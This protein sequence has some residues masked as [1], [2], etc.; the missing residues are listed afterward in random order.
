MSKL[1][2]VVLALFFQACAIA[3]QGYLTQAKLPGHDF[4]ATDS[5]LRLIVDAE[6]SIFST[7]GL[8]D[9]KRILC[10]EPSPDVATTLAHSLGASISVLNY[11]AGSLSAQQV[12]GLVQLGERTAAVQ[13]LR[14]KMYQICVAYANDAISATTYSLLMSRLDDSIVTLALGDGAAGAFGRKLEGIGGEAA[15]KP[16][17][18]LIGLP[19]EISKIEE[20]AGRLAAA[21]KRVDEVE[22]A[23]RVH[24]V[25]QPTTGKEEEYNAQSSKLE[26][27]L[28]TAKGARNALLELMRG[29]AK[30]ASEA[31]GKISPLQAG[32]GLS[33]SPE[34][35]VLREI[36]ADFLLT[37]VNRD[38]ISACLV[39]L[40]L[41]A[42]AGGDVNLEKMIRH[43]ETMFLKQ[44]EPTSTIAAS[45]AGAI[46]RHRGTALG[47][48]CQEHLDQLI[49]NATQK[50]HEYRM[51]RAQL[52]ADAASARY[53]GETAK[54]RA[55]DREL[56]IHSI[57]LCNTEFKNDAEQKQACLDQVIPMKPAQNPP[58]FRPPPG[59]RSQYRLPN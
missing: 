1:F 26:N 27:D 20:Q 11:G 5:R 46:L 55:R 22:K 34:V 51:R 23:L 28:A 37:D 45:Y 16:E 58:P 25:T 59:K 31:S 47:T 21:D 41:R 19:G 15:A 43:L 38:F 29:T 32:G 14:D 50:L 52:N 49:T 8:V 56:F 4:I 6:Q 53:A 12:E 13:L 44:S 9:P 18:T 30:S 42:G 24:R 3:P 35:S 10:T 36:H 7:S 17:A 39:E 57:K 48:F 2:L 40:G 54:A 33:A